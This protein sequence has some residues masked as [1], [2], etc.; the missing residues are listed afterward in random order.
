MKRFFLLLVLSVVMVQVA[1]AAQLELIGGIRD[2]LAFGIMAE[3]N[4]ARNLGL[5][6]GIE[7]DTGKQPVIGFIGGK[8][9]LT[10]FERA[11]PL[12]LGVGFVGYFGGQHTDAGVSLSL[13][14]NRAFNLKPL[15]IEA[16]VDVAGSG[17][18][19]LQVG[20]KIY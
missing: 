6:Y 9:Y 3:Q 16:G 11:M 19:Q 8:F 20:Y 12:S 10:D 14:I 1:G 4:V 5:R 13:I 17:R 15:F 7:A 18:L 2:G